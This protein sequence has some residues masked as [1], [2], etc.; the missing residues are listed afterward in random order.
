LG[1]GAS[2]FI[3]E[4]IRGGTSASEITSF[5][6]SAGAEVVRLA[7]ERDRRCRSREKRWE[8]DLRRAARS[9]A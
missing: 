9:T 3:E 1:V 4:E 6:T 2:T 8:T 5:P 7:G